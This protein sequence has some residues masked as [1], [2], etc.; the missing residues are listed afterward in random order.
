[1][2]IVGKYDN[3]LLEAVYGLFVLTFALF[4]KGVDV[5]LVLLIV[6]VEPIDDCFLFLYDLLVL[7]ALTVILLLATFEHLFKLEHSIQSFVI[8]EHALIDE[9]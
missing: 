3:L 6:G 4:L 5:L 9:L 2:V 8:F 1:M 7:E